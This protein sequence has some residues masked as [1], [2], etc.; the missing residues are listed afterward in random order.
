[1]SKRHFIYKKQK[2]KNYTSLAIL[3]VIIVTL[4]FVTMI[5]IAVT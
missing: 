2:A 1:M 4:F 5:K 3:L